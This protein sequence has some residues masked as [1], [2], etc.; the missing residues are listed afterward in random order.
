M[1]GGE[2]LAASCLVTFCAQE[3]RPRYL[4]CEAHE[5]VEASA[6]ILKEKIKLLAALIKKSKC[7]FLYT[8]AGISTASGIP[9]YATK[10]VDGLV[11][12]GQSKTTV[13]PALA[14][15]TLSYRV[16]VALHKA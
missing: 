14:S 11:K 12:K 3:A 13:S 5:Y 1:P 16:L 6:E 8:G 15:P 7:T 10:A 9:H 4:T 2:E